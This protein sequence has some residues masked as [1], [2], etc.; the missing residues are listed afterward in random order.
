[1]EANAFAAELLMPTPALTA[2]MGRVAPTFAEVARIA[3]RCLTTFTASVI[4]LVELTDQ[5]AIAVFSSGNGIVWHVSN[6]KSEHLY[7]ERGACIGADS[8][9]W[10]C[11]ETV[12]ECGPPCEVP[13]E[14]WFPTYQY[15][16]RLEVYEQSGNLGAYDLTVT[17]LTPY[18][19]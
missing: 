15:L 16:D 1:M 3:G 13:G 18:D 8:S 17:L 6:A 9:A 2:D 10:N 12:G 7:L 14:A 5:P 4:R 19:A 11:L